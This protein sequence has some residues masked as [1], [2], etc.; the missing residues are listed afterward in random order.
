MPVFNYKACDK[1]GKVVN[2][3]MEGVDEAAVISKLQESGSYPLNITMQEQEGTAGIAANVFSAF[4]RVSNK[5][6]MLFTQQLGILTEA[7][8]PLDRSLTI[9][10]DL[11]EN[12]KLAEIIDNILKSV[13]GGSSLTEAMGRHPRIFSG[14]YINMVKAGESG[15]VIEIVIKRLSEFLTSS[16]SLKDDVISAMIYPSLLTLVA[17]SAVAILLLF[18]VPKFADMF[19]DMG[20]A[21]PLPTQLLLSFTDMLL[22]YWWLLLG[23]VVISVIGFRYYVGTELGKYNWDKWKLKAPFLGILIQKIEAA[24]FT[25]TLGTLIQSGV[26]IL[27]GVGIVKDI[28]GNSVIAQA[29]NKISSS[30]KEGE[31]VT[32]PL[33]ENKVFPPLV[34]HMIGIGEETGQLDSM[35]I[36]VADIYDVEVRNSI[37]RLVALL[38]PAMILFMGIVVGFIIVAMLLAIFSVNEMPF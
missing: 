15:G 1:R 17:G 35:L 19:A 5:D 33:K 18:V 27:Q 34:I 32:A 16:Q 14:L 26:P 21:L 22:A 3:T 13:Q 10:C 2:G 11:T 24:R 29:M 12:K 28:I 9:L 38:E 23:G 36:K 20:Q 6:V 8:L 31:G 25:R 4:Q 7:G 37:K 30:L